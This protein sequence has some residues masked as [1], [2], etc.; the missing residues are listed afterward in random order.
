MKVTFT[1]ILALVLLVVG[2]LYFWFDDKDMATYS[3]LLAIFNLVLADK[4]R[5]AK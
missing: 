5:D 4:N 2:L 1:F 3:L